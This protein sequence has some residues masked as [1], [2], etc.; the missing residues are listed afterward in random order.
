MVLGTSHL[1][2]FLLTRFKESS[3]EYIIRKSRTGFQLDCEKLSILVFGDSETLEEILKIRES[4]CK[5]GIVKSMEI[6][7]CQA[8]G[9]IILISF[10]TLFHSRLCLEHF[11]GSKNPKKSTRLLEVS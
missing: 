10:F 11:S 7:L 9:H 4:F 2:T 8:D 5:I 6:T 3:E 1:G